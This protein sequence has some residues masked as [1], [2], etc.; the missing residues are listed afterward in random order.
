MSK[1]I[2]QVIRYLIFKSNIHCIVVNNFLANYLIINIRYLNL[3][4]SLPL[5][6]I[7]TVIDNMYNQTLFIYYSNGHTFMILLY[8]HLTVSKVLILTRKKF[9]V[10]QKLHLLFLHLLGDVKTAIS[11]SILKAT[12]LS[13]NFQMYFGHPVLLI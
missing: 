7:Y 8:L 10:R 2:F 9:S 1:N 6:V 13:F 11:Y 5:L 3:N 4:T 12:W